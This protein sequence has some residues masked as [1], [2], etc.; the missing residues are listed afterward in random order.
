M[1]TCAGRA[2]G[3]DVIV[4]HVPAYGPHYFHPG[5]AT[6]C[7]GAQGKEG[8]SRIMVAPQGHRLMAVYHA[9]GTAVRVSV[10]EVRAWSTGR[11]VNL[12]KP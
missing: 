2:P 5:L 12:D 9:Q 7:R 6:P 8:Y 1:G 10:R 4:I 11:P 3:R